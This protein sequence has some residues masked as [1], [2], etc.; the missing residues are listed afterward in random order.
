[1]LKLTMLVAAM[2]AAAP[3]VAR[4]EIPGESVRVSVRGLDL[5]T[6]KGRAT[7]QSRISDGI[8]QVCPNRANVTP[9]LW[10]KVDICRHY[11]ADGARRQVAAALARL[12]AAAPANAMAS[13]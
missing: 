5:S 10:K 2:A 8:D 11:A 1:M 4:D 13:K 6:D 9:F 3:A 7:L 12:Q